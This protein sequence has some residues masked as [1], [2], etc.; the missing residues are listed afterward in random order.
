MEIKNLEIKPGQTVRVH[1]K[2][3]EKNAKGEDKERVQ[4][5]EGIVLNRRHGSE[6]GATI[7]VRKISDNI[8][9]EKIF[10]LHSPTIVKVELVKTAK[11][12]RA[13]LSYL[14]KGYKKKLKEKR[15]ISEK[16]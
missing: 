5:F 6:I 4:V 7:C 13:N 10:P 12:R 15:S 9:V 8:G 1:Q 3:K 2:I 16:K 11:V 14:T